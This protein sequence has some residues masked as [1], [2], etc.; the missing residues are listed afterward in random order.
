MVKVQYYDDPDNDRA[1]CGHHGEYRVEAFKGTKSSFNNHHQQFC[2]K[3]TLALGSLWCRH[4]RV[5]YAQTWTYD[6]SL[7]NKLEIMNNYWYEMNVNDGEI[8]IT[9]RCTRFDTDSWWEPNVVPNEWQLQIIQSMYASNVSNMV[10]TTLLT[11]NAN[12][13]VTGAAVSNPN[14][15]SSGIARSEFRYKARR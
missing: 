4:Y 14:H 7:K 5:V 10:V 15:P 9:A 2:T 1:V 3:Y 6:S 8:K 11:E 12:S 13:M